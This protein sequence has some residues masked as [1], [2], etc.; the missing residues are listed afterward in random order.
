MTT[1]INLDMTFTQICSAVLTEYKEPI[2]GSSAVPLDVVK[3]AVNS[4][5]MDIFNEPEDDTYLRESNF[6][7]AITPDSTL[8]GGLAVGATSIVLQSAV[9]F[10]NATRKILI[11]SREFATYGVSDLTTTLSSVTEVQTTHEDGE[12]V[13]LGYPLS[14]ITDIDEQEINMVKVDGMHYEFKQPSVWLNR[15]QYG[16]Y[17]IF[18]GYFF[19]PETAQAQNVQMIYN[20][21]LTLM[22]TDG[23]K[24][25][26]IPG[27]FREA[28]L[29]SGAI[30]RIGV[31]DDM[32]TGFEWHQA[33]YYRELKKFYA[34]ANNRIK[35]KG[36]L[37]RP[38]V[39]D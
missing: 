3:D 33:R 10:P 38:S 31:R 1:Y 39:Y 12:G 25:S 22:V 28:L 9:N 21:K 32:R 36:P 20:K 5:Y 14:S 11:N 18:D 35:T 30:T 7:F 2:A 15:P 23:S 6:E 4:V 37:R 29:V 27:K 13:Q 19:F 17:T 8:N 24:P 16:F 34:F 26:L